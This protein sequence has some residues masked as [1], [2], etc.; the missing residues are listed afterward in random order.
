MRRQHHPAGRQQH[1]GEQ[2][3]PAPARPQAGQCDADGQ[4]RVGMARGEGAEIVATFEEIKPV[5]APQHQG[6]EPRPPEDVLE[7]VH[8][9]A[10]SRDAEKDEGA[11]QTD[12]LR[13]D[14]H[15]R[16]IDQALR[17]QGQHADQRRR[18][19]HPERVARV[20]DPGGQPIENK[21]PAAKHPGQ[22]TIDPEDAERR[23]ESPAEEQRAVAGRTRQDAIRPVAPAATHRAAPARR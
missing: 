15:G 4:R 12:P 8:Q 19:Q 7:A 9:H 11:R 2:E 10:G 1:A 23:G 6:V 22:R 13:A 3:Q 16:R 17:Q 21:R 20:R 18:G 14:P 5:F